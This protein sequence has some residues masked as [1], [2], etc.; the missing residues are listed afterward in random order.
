MRKLLSGSDS[1]EN[2]S[3]VSG[4]DVIGDLLTKRLDG[5]TDSVP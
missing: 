4:R 2:C 3:N 5:T 1:Y